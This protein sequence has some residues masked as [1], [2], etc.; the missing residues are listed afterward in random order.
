MM[1]LVPT[2]GTVST[3]IRPLRRSMDFST[4]SSPT[5]RP[6]RSV[7]A[8]R[9]EKPCEKMS[10]TASRSLRVSSPLRMPRS[11]ALRYTRAASMPAPSSMM[12]ITTWL[13]SWAAERRMVPVRVFPAAT[14]A[15]GVSMPWSTLLRMRWTRGSPISSMMALST[16]V[17]SPSRMSSISLPCSWARSRT[18][19][20]KRSKTWRTGSMRMS[21]TVSWSSADTPPTCCT[22]AVSS[23][24]AARPTTVS[25]R[26]LASWS[27]LVRYTISSPTRLS[28]WSSWEK[29]TRTVLERAAT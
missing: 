4:T 19:R 9:V 12:V 11:T 18:R 21:I 16:R 3:S 29:S 15:S 22:A 1:N 7:T 10:C 25:V 14:R 8:S 6:E 17:V 28:R 20:G 2:P 26:S 24:P 27:S 5:P 23:R 13:E